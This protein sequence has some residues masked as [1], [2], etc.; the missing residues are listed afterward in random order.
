MRIALL[1]SFYVSA[2]SSGENVVVAAQLEALSAAGHDVLLIGRETDREQEH[3]SAYPVRAAWRTLTSRGPDPAPLLRRF[4]PEVVHVHNT[5][6]NIGL[7]WLPRWDGPVVH[8]LH[9]YRPLCA[10]GLLFRDG[11]FCSD[12]PDGKPWSAVQHGCYRDSRVYSLPIAARNA[13][14]LAANQLLQRSDALV[15]LSEAARQIYLDYGVPPARLRLVPNGIR[16]VHAGVTEG[17]TQPRWL[18]VG[19]L[20]AE[21]GFEELLRSWPEDEPLDIIGDGPQRGELQAMAPRGVRLLGSMPADQVRSAMSNY[22]AL[23]FP[24]LAIESALPLVASEALE[25]SLPVVFGAGHRQSDELIA[26]GV[27][28]AARWE[29]P[30]GDP[31]GITAALAWVRE[32]GQALRATARA[33]YD[34]HLTEE[35]WIER[36]TE[37]YRETASGGRRT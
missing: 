2:A 34:D 27:A 19:R 17:P 16:R 6:P 29:A 20:R 13:R 37:L 3:L 24:G 36:L 4:A 22:S 31:Q 10:N 11:R 30:P 33:W 25:A 14:G 26:A 18:A 21:K 1:H 5:V 8:T 12:C 28:R 9:N 7:Q 15:V 35:G 32:G 23:I